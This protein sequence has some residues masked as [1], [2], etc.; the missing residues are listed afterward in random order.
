M[1]QCNANLNGF[2]STQIFPFI[3]FKKPAGD[4]CTT[5]WTRNLILTYSTNFFKKKI[6]CSAF[7]MFPGTASCKISSGKTGLANTISVSRAML[8]SFKPSTRRWYSSFNFLLSFS[9]KLQNQ[10]FIYDF[11]KNNCIYIKVFSFTYSSTTFSSVCKL[12]EHLSKIR[13]LIF[14]LIESMQTLS[15]KI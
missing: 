7:L 5:C 12:I 3:S 6:K 13:R 1:K 11:F 4:S 10:I 8:A 14:T 9:F 15:T 2:L